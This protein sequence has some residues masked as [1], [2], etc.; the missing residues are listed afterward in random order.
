MRR[1]G[2]GFQGLGAVR[3]VFRRADD[4]LDL[5]DQRDG[6]VGGELRDPH[7]H[8]ADD[9]AITGREPAEHAKERSPI[10]VRP[11]LDEGG[12]ERVAAHIP[13]NI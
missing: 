3:S 10:R 8:G 4:L 1:D 2:P 5:V 9:A 6:L 7:Q 11:M 13:D 12:R